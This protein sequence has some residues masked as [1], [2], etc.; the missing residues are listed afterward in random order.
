MDAGERA[1]LGNEVLVM[2]EELLKTH[3]RDNVPAETAK[4]ARL[5]PQPR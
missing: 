5:A 3:P 4:A 2:F 1:G